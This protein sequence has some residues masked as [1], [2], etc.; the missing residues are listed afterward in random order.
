MKVSPRPLFRRFC[1][2]ANDAVYWL[3]DEIEKRGLIDDPLHSAVNRLTIYA[4]ILDAVACGSVSP[5]E[6]SEIADGL[7]LPRRS[8]RT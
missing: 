5:E 8:A 1:D 3:H 6:L 4:R 2:G 7:G